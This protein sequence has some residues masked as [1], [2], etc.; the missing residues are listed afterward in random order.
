VGE[1]IYFLPIYTDN[2]SNKV[3]TSGLLVTKSN[4]QGQFARV[5][6]CKLYL[7]IEVDE[8]FRAILNSSV[9]ELADDWLYEAVIFPVDGIQQSILTLV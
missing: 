3:A 2:D 5:G 7:N 9:G 1:K 8:F 4:K 6:V